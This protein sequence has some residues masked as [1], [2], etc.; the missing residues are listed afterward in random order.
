MKKPSKKQP[1]I[2][3]V[4]YE[5]GVKINVFEYVEPTRNQRTFNK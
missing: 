5:N 4:Y 2:I 1:K 3:K